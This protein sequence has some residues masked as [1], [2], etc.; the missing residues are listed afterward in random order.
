[1]RLERQY[2]FLARAF[3]AEWRRRYGDD[4]VTTLLDG[5]TD[6]QRFVSLT[7]VADVAGRGLQ[8]RARTV[9]PVAQMVT[10]GMAAVLTMTAVNST[11]ESR[12]LTELGAAEQIS[13]GQIID[14]Q[15]E[16]VRSGTGAGQV[17][18]DHADCSRVM[19]EQNT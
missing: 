18:H 16:S 3:P 1:M 2:Q 13:E 9:G 10:F 11:A 17:D 7:D 19:F 8:T 5:S 15:I 4:L 14:V 12:P 6:G